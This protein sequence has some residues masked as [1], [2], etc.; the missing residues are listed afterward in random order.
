MSTLNDFA[1][2]NKTIVHEISLEVSCF[3]SAPSMG[4]IYRVKVP[5]HEGRSSG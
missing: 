4:V 5:N 2:D 1:G 3:F